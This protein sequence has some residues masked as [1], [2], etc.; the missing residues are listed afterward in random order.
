M[1]GSRI[2]LL[3]PALAYLNAGL[4]VLPAHLRL[5]YAAINP[6]KPYQAQ[7]PARAEL[8]AWFRNGSEALCIVAGKVSGN[9][10]TLDFDL[11]G[12]AFAGWCAL[13]NERSPGL[14]DRLAI[15][16]SPSGG[17]HAVYR[18]E[19]AI[20][21]SIKLAQ[22]KMIVDSGDPIVLHGKEYV[23][24]KDKDGQWHV[25]LTLIETRGEGGLFLCAPSPGYELVQGDFAKLPVLTADERE[26]LL[27]AAWSMNEYAPEPVGMTHA[28][29]Y[30]AE[31]SSA[32]PGDDFNARG[33][34]RALLQKHGWTRVK[35]GEN[36]YWR[37]PGK[38]QG[39]SATLKK[40][41]FYVFSSNAAP[42]EPQQAYAPFALYAHLEHNGDFTRAAGALRAEGFGGETVMCEVDLSRLD[43]SADGKAA[44]PEIVDPGML[45]ADLF[46]VPGF[47]AE[48]ADFCLQTA[49]YPNP[50]TAFCG[51]LA[52]QAV[53]AG[54]KVRDGGDCRTNI[55]L[56]SLAHSASGKDHPRKINTRILHQIGLSDCVGDRFASGEGIQ[57]AL[58]T[59]PAM[60]FQSDEFDGMLQS[61]NRAKDARYENIMSTLLTL[62]SASN[63]VFPMRRKANAKEPPGVIDQPCLVV[64][65][66]AD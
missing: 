61:I 33:D 6:W 17:Y 19:D 18:C 41:V 13:V 32:R 11:A 25:I 34:V 15:E 54:R 24:R 9:L 47:I 7:L 62:Y 65:G 12:E 2:E 55:Y 4:S 43:F 26:S 37:R 22:R 14:L 45:P 51:A 46:H 48:V 30:A 28:Q 23:P 29:A 42:F 31:P 57:D 3:D 52:L 38:S 58:F 10:E 8:E 59:T 50:S 44:T 56:L 16:R 49:P 39:W 1:S 21:G 66:T 40:N 53:L 36:E 5:K 27:E 60:L 63:S 64:L 35:G 20:C